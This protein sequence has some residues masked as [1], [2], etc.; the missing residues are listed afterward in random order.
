MVLSAKEGQLGIGIP[1]L[2][3]LASAAFKIV[4]YAATTGDWLLASPVNP[5]NGL[6]GTN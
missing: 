5:N 6:A 3:T 4:E 2:L 1:V